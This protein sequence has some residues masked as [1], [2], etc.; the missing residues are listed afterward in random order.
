MVLGLYPFAD[1][2]ADGAPRLDATA[3]EELVRVERAAAL[4]LGPRAPEPPGTLFLTTRRVIWIGEGGKGYAVDFIAVS[5]HAVSRDPE[6]YPSPCIYTQIETEAGSDEESDES[7][8]EIN[9]EIEV[10]KVTEMRIIPSDP[11]QLDGLFE[12][13]SLCAELNPDPNAES[14]E[15]NGWVHGD[16]GDEDMTDGSDAEFSD[17]NPI[18][19]TDDRD[20]THAVVELQINDQR[21]QDAEEADEE[22]NRNW[23]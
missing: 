17:V 12:A 7:D 11:G 3:E 23:H 13:F 18:G 21:F 6:A 2:A 4:A 10:S 9:G 16:E 8:S 5:L 15:E 1:V 19:Q 14:D 22:S 20:I